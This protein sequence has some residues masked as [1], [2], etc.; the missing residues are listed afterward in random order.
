[1]KEN[2]G[3]CATLI[4]QWNAE[5]QD[6]Q[7]GDPWRPL[8]AE[9]LRARRADWP[10]LFGRAGVKPG[11]VRL[12]HALVDDIGDGHVTLRSTL[13]RRDTQ[14]AGALYTMP[15]ADLE[16]WVP[17]DQRLND[18]EIA[19]IETV[20]L[21]AVASCGTFATGGCFGEALTYSLDDLELA[22]WRDRYLADG[23]LLA[24]PPPSFAERP[25]LRMA[26]N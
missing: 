16:F 25:A 26:A 9:D 7:T 8:I 12:H 10:R 21:Y 19:H 15:L 1:M 4:A 13:H 24:R 6:Y 5:L 3:R 11:D 22:G 17:L 18:A 23:R 14:P 20:S 2:E